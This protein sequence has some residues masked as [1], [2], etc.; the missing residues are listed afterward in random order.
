MSDQP[1]V[2]RAPEI[3]ALERLHD[4][5]T[6]PTLTID[7]KID[8]M[9]VVGTDRLGTT[10]GL[11]TRIE[12]GQQEI[13]RAVGDGD[14]EPGLTVP[15][16][17]AY[18]RHTIE[19]DEPMAVDDAP[20][21]GWEDDPA[22]EQFG[23]DC[24]LG[25]TIRVNHEQ[26]GTVCFIDPE[27][28]E[29]AFSEREQTFAELLT[30]WIHYLLEQQEY[31][32]ELEQQ[33]AFTESLINSL[34]DPLY[35]FDENGFVRWNARLETVTG[36]DENRL[37]EMDPDELVV[38]RDREKFAEL[39]ARVRDGQQ[40]TIRADLA[41]ADGTSR[42]YELSGAPLRDET[43]GIAGVVGTGR[44]IS[45][46][47]SH[48]QRLSGLLDTTQS[49][50][51]VREL[52]AVAE[53]AVNAAHDLLGFDISVF[54]LY[55]SDAGTLEPAA[56]TGEALETL[57]D[58]PVYEVGSGH[59]GEVFASGESRVVHDEAI[60]DDLEPIRSAMY[61]PVGVRGTMSVCSTDPDAFDETD[62]QMLALL[63]TNAAA[64]CDRAKREQAVREARAHTERVLDRVN[65]LIQ[66]TIEVLVEA[67]TR[68]EIERGVVDELA[69]TE[70]YTF[71][72]IGRPDL[73]SETLAPAAWDGDV[74]RSVA[75]QSFA[76]DADTPVA[77]AYSEGQSQVLDDSAE[78]WVDL[79]GDTTGALIA[80]PLV[81]RETTY[82]VLTVFADDI[83]AFDERERVVLNA[84]GG[85]VANAVN[86]VE[87][88]RILD[89]TEIIEL[90]FAVSDP[91]LLFNRL[92]GGTDGRLESASTEYQSDGSVRLYLSATGVD[93][94]QF[95]EHARQDEGIESVTCIVEH[96][97]ECL[98]EI[99]VEESLLATLAEYGAVPKVV[100]A[101]NGSTRFTVELPY[102]AE[103]RELF[104]LVEERYPGTELLGYHER[105]RPVETR[106]DFRAA[107][108]ENLTDRQETALRTAYLGG[109]FDW[110][111]DVDGNELA[112][113]MDISRPTYHQHLRAA[114]EKVLAELFD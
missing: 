84:L 113:A 108:S 67:T 98:V 70:P 61:Y 89:A 9:L 21:E 12:N 38:E 96:D 94:E 54:R 64:A 23:F 34:P 104:E 46:Q 5:A 62:E 25:A 101:E 3:D 35:A 73:T 78:E 92:S 72:W 41:V 76:L 22:Y 30:N 79:V 83:N 111:R 27:A 13:V 85:A 58:R 15:L 53:T 7:G 109:F 65:G 51:N 110:P 29:S 8:R 36:H 55:D 90:E 18:C 28:R 24:Y 82:G 33:Q 75:D 44:D 56:A 2:S 4:I 103:A 106:Q 88:G 112:E 26:Y 97:D 114:Q 50:M 100:V 39:V 52:T 14:I 80:V 42:P 6:D 16:S 31:E 10:Y 77:R 81:Y 68:E 59:P 91:E 93:P 69:A 11:L 49:L 20:A 74:A 45:E 48:Q 43:G 95:C 102:E 87:R 17:A 37:D 71:A 47:Q 105:E 1:T 57:G 63:A 66:N 40:A 86:A 107:I 60:S 19:S 32:R 99:V